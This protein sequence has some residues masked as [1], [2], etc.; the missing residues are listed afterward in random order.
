V[1]H[2]PIARPQVP[3]RL[4]FCSAHAPA[5]LPEKRERRALSTAL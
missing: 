5:Y 2:S 3:P 1:R 4:S